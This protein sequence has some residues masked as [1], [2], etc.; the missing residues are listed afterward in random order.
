[1]AEEGYPGFTVYLLALFLA[2]LACRRARRVADREGLAELGDHAR[3]LE[4][5]LAAFV[6]GSTFV[7]LHYT[8][9]TWHMVGLSMALSRLAAG[10]EA[11][12]WTPA[13]STPSRVAVLTGA[14][15]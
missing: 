2:V 11:T 14:D 8:E 7:N 12:V 1:V 5:S 4:A 3:A 6:V 15:R 9:M 10:A 13:S